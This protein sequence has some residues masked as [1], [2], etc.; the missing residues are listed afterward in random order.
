M[1]FGYFIVIIALA[2]VCGYMTTKYFIY[3]VVLGQ[4]G[5][6]LSLSNIIGQ[7]EFFK[8]DDSDGEAEGNDDGS[9]GDVNGDGDTNGDGGV[10]E[11]K[12]IE[13]GL[14]VEKPDAAVGDVQSAGSTNV[15]STNADGASSSGTAG[16][17]GAAGYCVQYGSFSTEKAAGSMAEQL[18]SQGVSARVITKDNAYKVVGS[19]FDTREAAQAELSQRSA[20]YEDVF[21]TYI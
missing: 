15:G 19:P 21:V 4:A 16:T 2:V 10:G 1:N 6:G 3:P 14:N 9:G 11:G 17:A 12:V 13:D 20:V 7:H 8:N 5:E 18:R